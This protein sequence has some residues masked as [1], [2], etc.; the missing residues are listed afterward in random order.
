MDIYNE[1]LKQEK[2]FLDDLKSF[3]QIPSVS[4]DKKSLDL[5]VDYLVELS[6]KFNLD[7]KTHIDKQVVTINYGNIENNKE[8]FG[9][10]AHLDV[11]PVIESEWSFP[12]FDLT[13]KDGVLYGRGVVDDKTPILMILY[14]LKIL[15]ENNIETNRN[16]Q[17]I[18]GTQ[19][20]VIWTDINE[21]VKTHKLP[22]FGFTPDGSF[23]VQNAEKGYLDIKFIFPKENI[24]FVKGGIST[25]SIPSDFYCKINSKEYEAKGKSVHSSRPEDGINAIHVG[26]D[27]I[28]CRNKVFDFIKNYLFDYYGKQLGIY[29]EYYINNNILN[30]TTL[31]TTMIY[32]VNEKVEVIVNFRTA[33]N[34]T[35]DTILNKLNKLKNEY[36]FEYEVK[37]YMKPVYVDKG[38][39][40]IKIMKNVYEENTNEKTEFSLAT[41]ATYAKAIDNFVSFGPLFPNSKYSLH[42]ANEEFVFEELLL[43]Q[44]IYC[45]TIIKIVL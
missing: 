10:L 44:K 34:D 25:N 37:E 16:I 2:S 12:P 9:I 14:I 38:T 28:E 29:E 31:A 15:K 40:F 45:D 36:S 18:I 21:Y 20:E 23:P 24:E 39:Q 11:V 30:L 17:L 41:C 7:V 27:K 19:E 5:A 35:Y 3:L 43:A 22:N 13:I 26:I 4:D 8:T 6:K 33:K 1:F 42:E 32:S